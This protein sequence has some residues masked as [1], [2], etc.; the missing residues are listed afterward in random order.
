M[1]RLVFLSIAVL[2]LSLPASKAMGA[3][4]GAPENTP[5]NALE[6]VERVIYGAPGT[7]GM[8]LRLARAERDLFGMELPGSL[9]ERQQSLLAFVE[10]GNGAQPSLVF[11]IA[12]AEWVT[13]AS[14]NPSAP[15]AERVSS[16][17][18]LLEEN[19]QEG[20]LSTR[21]ER[22][23]TKLL[24]NGVFAVPI[25]IPASTVFKAAFAKTL[26]VRNVSVGDVVELKI[27]EDCIIGGT[28]AAAKGNRIFAEVTKVKMPRSFGRPSEISVE[29]KNAE[30]IGG[31]L[32]PVLIGPEAKKA[33]EIDPG[34]IGAVGT[35][36]VGAV[37]VGPIGLA[38]GFLVRG[39]DKKIPEGTAVYVETTEL[40]SV[41]GYQVLGFSGA[42]TSGPAS[43]EIPSGDVPPTDTY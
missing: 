13:Q 22:I 26:T 4:D 34:T 6:K 14:V 20:A 1:K 19:V 39:S 30:S 25:Q 38:G 37:L 7:G 33:M 10:E 12:V 29:F 42:V 41:S 32:T 40:A 18:S 31:Q 3:D 9:T 2:F 24:P 16:L 15:L 8:F 23:L 36:F 35:S 17:E 21:L 11:K 5:L 28:L 27:E 43:A